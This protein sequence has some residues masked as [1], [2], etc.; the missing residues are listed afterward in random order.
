M[1]EIPLV[2]PGAEFVWEALVEIAP[3]QLLGDG[4][5]GER[6]IVPIT[7]GYFAPALMF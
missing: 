1:T 7:G 2:A 3:T 5:L 4:P 6:R